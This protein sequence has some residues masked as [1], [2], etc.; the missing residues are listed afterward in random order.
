MKSNIF[1]DIPEDIFT[2]SNFG[3]LDIKAYEVF[4]IVSEQIKHWEEE[5]LSPQEAMEALEIAPSKMYGVGFGRA[6]FIDVGIRMIKDYKW[7]MK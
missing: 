6:T 1:D 3:P 4:F 7:L 2:A 5:G